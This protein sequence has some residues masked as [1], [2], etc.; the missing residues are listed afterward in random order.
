MIQEESQLLVRG[1]R[2]S[3]LVFIDKLYQDA[4]F[5]LDIPHLERLVVVE[6]E[7]EIV[8][9]GSLTTILEAAFVTNPNSRLRK[10]TQGLSLLAKQAE[11]ETKSIGYDLYHNFVTDDQVNRTLKKHFGFEDGKGFNLIKFIEEGG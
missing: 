5:K 3:D 4:G 11:S 2:K 8:A 7:G 6:D 10:R 1:A 9:V